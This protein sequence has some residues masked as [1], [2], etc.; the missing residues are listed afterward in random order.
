MFYILDK[1]NFLKIWR[2]QLGIGIESFFISVRGRVKA[3]TDVK[4]VVSGLGSPGR[5]TYTVTV[6]IH[7][8]FAPKLARTR[9]NGE[10][11]M[12]T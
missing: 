6:D 8:M 9:D 12:V 3:W 10:Y 2:F 5:F 1:Q 4:H 11:I 7:E